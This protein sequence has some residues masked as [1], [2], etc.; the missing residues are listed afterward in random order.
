[1]PALEW[2]CENEDAIDGF[3]CPGHVSV[4]IGSAAYE[5]LAKQYEKPFVVAGFEPEH[6]LAGIYDIVGQLEHK[7]GYRGPQSV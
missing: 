1:M 6:I 3:L 2:I 4:I 5:E 7:T